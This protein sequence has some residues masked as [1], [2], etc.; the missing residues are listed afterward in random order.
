MTKWCF[1][2]KVPHEVDLERARDLG[3]SKFPLEKKLTMKST[4][5][6][7]WEGGFDVVGHGG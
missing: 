3:L 1:L 2:K 7:N 5:K 4:K 6:M